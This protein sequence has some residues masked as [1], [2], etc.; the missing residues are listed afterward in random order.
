VQRE[1]VQQGNQSPV[2]G[3]SETAGSSAILTAPPPAEDSGFWPP[4]PRTIAE[5]GLMVPFVEDHLLRLLYFELQMT[6]AELAATC[7][8]P[9]TVIQPLINGLNR[10]H[11]VEVVG[12][13]SPAEPG[14]RYSLAPK[15]R[16]RVAEAL[17]R[18]W[19]HG[20]LPVPLDQ[21][22]AGVKAQSMGEMDFHREH[23]REAFSDLVLS[24]GLLDRLGP[25]INTNASIFLHGAPGNGKTVIAERIARMIGGAIFIPYAFEVD[26]SI[27][28]L[29]DFLNHRPVDE[30]D[31]PR[32]DA[33]W[34]RV[35]RPAIIASSELTLAS[36]DLVRNE[37]GK[38]YEAPPQ[39]KSNGGTFL[40]DDFG[41]QQVR[42]AELLNRWII[43]LE[44]R[45]DYMTLQTGKKFEVPFDTF[46][47]IST[48][49]DPSTM[50]DEAF[51]RR[52]PFRI[53]VHDPDE[54]QFEELF[55][56]VCAARNVTFDAG[57]LEWLLD[58]WFRP[59]NRPKRFV[60]PRNLISQVVAISKYLG[61]E[62]AM[63]PELLDRAC[64]NYFELASMP[65][66]N[67]SQFR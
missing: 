32:Y 22:V 39:M 53:P 42:P 50:A 35:A 27:V 66:S 55:R 25:A 56:S 29:Y 64:Q 37:T 31:V 41:R 51:Q 34:L 30:P 59:S 47:L 20:P 62:P 19:Y 26:G 28:L 48:N 15:G 14:Y 43:P 10:D 12:Q 18:T 36:L 54:A 65:T 8:V 5:T 4:P 33:R 52:V 24:N 67:T 9:Y 38:F 60:Q 57:A 7:G 11:M 13:A 44:R 21:Y 16:A 46:L 2:N 3:L 58:T 45:I 6:G 17:N 49:L 1:Y 40:I 61:R 63:E 23:L